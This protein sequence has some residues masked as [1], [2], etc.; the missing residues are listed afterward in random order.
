MLCIIN[1]CIQWKNAFSTRYEKLSNSLAIRGN[2]LETY[3]GAATPTKLLLAHGRS[4]DELISRISNI[5]ERV[6]ELENE[7]DFTVDRSGPLQQ[8]L[9][10]SHLE[11]VRWLVNWI[12]KILHKSRLSISTLSM[13]PWYMA[14]C[15]SLGWGRPIPSLLST[16]LKS[17]REVKEK[18]GDRERWELRRE[19]L[20]HCLEQT[21]SKWWRR[22]T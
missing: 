6:E 1:Y 9:R 16:S 20:K 22:S 5:T 17:G 15:F 7:G 3:L 18:K 14:R 2:K 11:F 12:P 19:E 10:V 4:L 13:K 21:S 8:N